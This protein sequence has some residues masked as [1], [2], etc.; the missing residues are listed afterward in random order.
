M[1]S[2]IHYCIFRLRL[3]GAFKILINDNFIKR[4]QHSFSLLAEVQ[5]A[6][7]SLR[8]ERKNCIHNDLSAKSVSCNAYNHFFLRGDLLS[9][10]CPRRLR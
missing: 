4:P 3:H 5:I 8:G 2:R 6:K 7:S 9:F 1:P 10:L